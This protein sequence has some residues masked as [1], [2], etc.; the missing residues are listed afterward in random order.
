VEKI[1]VFVPNIGSDT[2]K[3]LTEALNIG[4]LGMGTIT[5][6]FEESIA[7]YLGLRNRFVVTTHPPSIEVMIF[8]GSKL[9]QAMSP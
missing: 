1:P 6:E 7:D 8:T 4:W 2:I 3:H 5:K 9:K